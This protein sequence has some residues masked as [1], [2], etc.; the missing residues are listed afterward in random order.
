M[1]EWEPP[2]THSSIK[3]MRKPEN[4]VKNEF[5]RMLESNQRFATIKSM[6]SFFFL[7]KAESQ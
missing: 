4:I 7:K 3:G 1:A 6:L 2:K 5:F